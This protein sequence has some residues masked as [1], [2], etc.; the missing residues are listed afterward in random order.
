MSTPVIDRA[1]GVLYACAWV[2]PDHS[3]HWQ[4]GEHFVVALD[5]TTGATFRAKRRSVWKGRRLIRVMA[6]PYSSFAASNANNGPRWPWSK[7]L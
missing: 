6:C 2:S 7:A 4:T 1:A 5:I 3:G